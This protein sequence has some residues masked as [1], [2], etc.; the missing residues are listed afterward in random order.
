MAPAAGLLL[1]PSL[2]MP[3]PS[4]FARARIS[5]V[6]SVAGIHAHPSPDSRASRTPRIE[7]QVAR[8]RVVAALALDRGAVAARWKEED[9]VG[10]CCREEVG[11]G[12]PGGRTWWKEVG[13]QVVRR[14][15]STGKG[16]P[17]EKRGQKVTWR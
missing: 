3:S 16:G 12:W 14:S 8:S 1:P 7:V 6:I 10:R 5:S 9:G 2:L 4:E 15:A 11:Q 17:T 13:D